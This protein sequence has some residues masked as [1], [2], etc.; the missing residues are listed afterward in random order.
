VRSL[1]QRKLDQ[2]GDVDR[3]LLSAASVQGYEFDSGVAARVLEMD[4]AEAEERLEVLDRIHGLVRLRRE[5]EFPDGTLVL[6]YQFVH[7][8]YQNAL[9]AT[10]RPTRRASYSGA[11]ARVLLDHYGEQGGII[12]GELALLLEAARDWGRAIEFFLA[13]A[14]NA[15]R[16]HAHQEAVV[17]ARRGLDLL[18]RVPDTIERSRRELQLLITLGSQLAHTLGWSSPEVGA[19]YRRAYALCRKA[20]EDAQRAPVMWGLCSISIVQAQYQ[21]ARAVAEEFLGLAQARRDSGLLL[22]AHNVM[23][24]TSFHVGDFAAAVMHAEKGMTFFATG[25]SAPFIPGEFPAMICLGYSGW[26]LWMTGFPDRARDRVYES[27]SLARRHHHLPGLAHALYMA[28]TL[29]WFRREPRV[30]QECAEAV[31]ELCTEHGFHF[32]LAGGN[33]M[34]G[35][36]LAAQGAEAGVARMRQSLDDWK[37]TGAMTCVPFHLAVLAEV[38]GIEGQAEEALSCVAQALSLAETTGECVYNAE[39]YRLR[40]ELLW[41]G[42]SLPTPD[43]ALRAEAE[44]CF[45]RAL[46]VARRQG[47]KSLELRAELSLA[48]L[49][50]EGGMR[51]EGR[52]LLAE[53]LGGFTEGRDTPDQQLA[54]AFLEDSA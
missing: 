28:A 27:V 14:E 4:A 54:R 41:R 48:H 2:L 5:Q 49:L 31:I 32:W 42:A 50:K 3:R 19:T 13:A 15:A 20:G 9:Y 22:L 40:G 37:A 33:L 16:V 23:L 36:A 53:T 43:Q 26:A 46:D 12:A 29:H 44:D 18:A 8:L 39:L 47:A 11:V 17:L 35:W 1:I 21:A 6:R 51:A 38:L 34:R 7:V 52:G 25:Q 24:G 45:R 10:L 30:A